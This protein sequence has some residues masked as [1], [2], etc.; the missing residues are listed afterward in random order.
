[1]TRNT[2]RV[3]KLFGMV[4][5]AA[6]VAVVSGQAASASPLCGLGNGKKATGKPILVGSIVGQTGPDDFS[7]GAKARRPISIA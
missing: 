7:A 5:A 6:F 3:L 2:S 4:V 1:M